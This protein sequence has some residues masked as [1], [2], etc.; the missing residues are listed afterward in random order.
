MTE[1]SSAK[2]PEV[3][4]TVCFKAIEI[5]GKDVAVSSGAN[6]AFTNAD[7]AIKAA[8]Q[9]WLQMGAPVYGDDVKRDSSDEVIDK[10]VHRLTGGKSLRAKGEQLVIWV[11]AL[12]VEYSTVHQSQP[13]RILMDGI[14]PHGQHRPCLPLSAAAQAPLLPS[15]S[16]T[17][18]A[19]VSV[20]SQK[21]QRR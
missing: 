10:T 16:E 15:Q 9:M 11:E 12:T 20:V 19:C 1:Y 8:E 18:S 14:L 7:M 13:V 21:I 2:L 17:I 3:V 4:Y 5:I 6:K